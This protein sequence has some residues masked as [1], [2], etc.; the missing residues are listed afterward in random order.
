MG[1]RSLERRQPSRKCEVYTGGLQARPDRLGS[2]KEARDGLHLTE[3]NGHIFA[4][5]GK[6]LPRRRSSSEQE[7]QPRSCVE[8]YVP[9]TDVWHPLP[10]QPRLSPASDVLAILV[11]D[12]PLRHLDLS[13]APKKGVKRGTG[14]LQDRNKKSKSDQ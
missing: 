12:T 11:I 2:L 10:T 13:A 4:A 5:G 1:G 9:Q 6:I 3:Y 7:S 14:S 8:Y